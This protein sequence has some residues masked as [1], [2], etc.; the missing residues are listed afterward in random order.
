[1][2]DRKPTLDFHEFL[3]NPEKFSNVLKAIQMS[4]KQRGDLM[5]LCSTAEELGLF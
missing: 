3:S 4:D 1:M 5:T 2:Q